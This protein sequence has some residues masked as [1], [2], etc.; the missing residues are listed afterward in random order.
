MEL[1]FTVVFTQ[2]KGELQITATPPGDH[3]GFHWKPASKD[4]PYYNGVICPF[5]ISRD[6]LTA[7][8][9]G[10]VWVDID[11]ELTAAVMS[12]AAFVRDAAMDGLPNC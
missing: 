11:E 10:R 8:A 12:A 6:C 7:L 5:N 2:P 4:Y 1:A 3:I 9:D